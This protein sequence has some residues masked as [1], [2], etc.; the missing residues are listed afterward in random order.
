M[1]DRK[2]RTQ[3][4]DSV[5]RCY[6]TWSTSYYR[7]YYRSGAAYPPVHTGIVRDELVKAKAGT[8]LDAGCGPASMLQDLGDL[9]LE[10]YGFDLTEEMVAEARRV[11]SAQGLDDDRV[12]MG[13]VLDRDSFR[14]PAGG[15]DAAICFGVM[16]H[17]PAE[18]DETVLRNLTA[19]VAP[20][21]L[22][23]AEARNQLFALFTLNRYSRDLFRDVLIGEKGLREN[24]RPGSRTA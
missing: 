19:A 20:G 13:S 14:I 23:L 7:D 21:G 12:W 5:R 4:E 15:Y 8:L 9:G 16:P 17:I 11:M 22:V 10:R 6:S 2:E 1:S 24:T 3:I 18:H